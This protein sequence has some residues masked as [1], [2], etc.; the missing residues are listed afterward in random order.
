MACPIIDLTEPI[1]PRSA[2]FLR[3]NTRA[4]VASS[5]AS[6]EG[7]PVERTDLLRTAQSTELREHAPECFCL[8]QV[9]A[10]GEHQISLAMLQLLGGLLDR[11][12]RARTRGVDSKCATVPVQTIGDARRGEIG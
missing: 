7:A 8:A 3:P 1:T 10:A 4:S 11:H 9:D 6:P 12:Q 5:V 2:S